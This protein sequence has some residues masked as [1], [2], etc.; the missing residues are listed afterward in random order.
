MKTIQVGIYLQD[1]EGF[2]IIKPSL[3]LSSK[4]NNSIFSYHKT[5]HL[6]LEL[7]NSFYSEIR[8]EAGSVLFF[9]PGILHQGN[10][11]S[12][13]LDFHLRFA[14]DS[15]KDNSLNYMDYKNYDTDFLI[16]DIYSEEFN[17]DSDTNSVRDEISIFSRFK[18]SIN[19]YTALFNVLYHLK[20]LSIKKK[21]DKIETPWKVNI[22]ANTIFQNVFK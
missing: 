2:R 17:I 22:F 19:Y 8:G 15:N 5:P 9:A 3:D 1:Q 10:S 16:P 14:N 18:N 21:R 13:R 12:E 4:S 7:P 6:P 11:I 20:Y